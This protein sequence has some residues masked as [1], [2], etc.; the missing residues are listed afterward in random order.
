M[1]ICT[2]LLALWFRMRAWHMQVVQQQLSQQASLHS[3]ELSQKR[4]ELE[5]AQRALV[6]AQDHGVQLQVLHTN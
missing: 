4:T 2:S 5:Q 3:A 1:I 6:T